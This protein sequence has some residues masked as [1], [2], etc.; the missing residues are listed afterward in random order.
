MSKKIKYRRKVEKSMKV[1]RPE[2]MKKRW[3]ENNQK[4][5]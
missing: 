1:R 3:K 5:K 2:K 4:K